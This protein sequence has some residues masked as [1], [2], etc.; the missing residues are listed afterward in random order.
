M[1]KSVDGSCVTLT[2]LTPSGK[3]QIFVYKEIGDNR[4]PATTVTGDT[5]AV[6]T[7]PEPTK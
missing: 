2:D 4:G 5:L 1:S 3:Y 6:K 7:P